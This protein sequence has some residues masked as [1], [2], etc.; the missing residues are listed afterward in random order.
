MIPQ[1]NQIVRQP[2]YV[3]AIGKTRIVAEAIS[4]QS[5]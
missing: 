4:Q 3:I 1:S 5:T 2:D